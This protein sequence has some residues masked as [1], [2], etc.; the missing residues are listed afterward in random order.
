MKWTLACN[1]SGGRNFWESL[2]LKSKLMNDKY[3]AT[4][5]KKV[6]ISW[7]Q[8]DH[9]QPPPN[10]REIHFN[11]AINISPSMVPLISFKRLT[12][13]L[14][15]RKWCNLWKSEVKSLF[16]VKYV[17]LYSSWDWFKMHLFVWNLSFNV[18]VA[19]VSVYGHTPNTQSRSCLLMMVVDSSRMLSL[20]T[21]CEIRPLSVL[22]TEKGCSVISNVVCIACIVPNINITRELEC[23]K[24]DDWTAVTLGKKK[25]QRKQSASNRKCK[26]KEPL[27]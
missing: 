21:N 12:Q 20:D 16:Y 4:I 14:T 22:T 9:G 8:S 25:I 11:G 1:I 19:I 18:Q 24:C 15:L 7:I 13:R 5:M 10:Q 26:Q 23:R 2:F 3:S 27:V 17:F 6:V